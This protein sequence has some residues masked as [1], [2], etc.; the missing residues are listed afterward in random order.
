MSRASTG[1]ID[2]AAGT[3][4]ALAVT[5]DGH[6]HAWGVNGSGQLGDGTRIKHERPVRVET[7][8]SVVQVAAG[9]AH[10]LALT[11]DGR[12]LAWGANARGQLGIGSTKSARHPTTVAALSDVVSIATGPSH[13]VAITRSGELYTWGANEHAQLGDGSRRD[14][15]APVRIALTEVVDAAAG[16]NHTLALL[17][18]G[19]V[20]SW[21]A[22]ERGQLGTG[23]TAMALAPS[24]IDGLRAVAVRAGR[25]FSA[26]IQPDGT[27]MTWGA[28]DSG[29]LGDGS[30]FD[31]LTPAR[32]PALHDLSTLALGSRHAI[33]VTASGDVWTWGR[34]VAPVEAMSD[35]AHWGPSIAAHV[36]LRPPTITPPSASYAA[37]QTISIGSAGKN[38]T[39][40]YTLDGSDPTVDST[41]YLA[42][43]VVAVSTTVKARAYASSPHVEPGAVASAFYVIDMSPPTIV[44]NV[45]P[46]SAGA[47]FIT[48]VVVTFECADDSGAVACPAPVTVS[49]D[50]ASQLVSG[51][52]VDAAG[53]QATAAVTLNVDQSPPSIVLTDSPDNSTTTATQ[54]LLTGRVFDTASGLAAALRCNG[55]DVPVVQEAFE[56]VV[57]LR[58]GV[59]HVTLYYQRHC[60]TFR[61]CRDRHHQGRQQTTGLTIAPNARTM[62][63]REVAPL[64][65][66]DE[67]G[68]AVSGAAW[69][70]SNAG[71]AVLSN[72][73]PPVVTAMAAGTATISAIKDGRIAESTIIVSSGSDAATRNRS[74]DHRTNTRVHDGAADLHAPRRSFGAR[75]VPRR[76]TRRGAKPPCAR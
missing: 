7:V 35:I 34:G 33:A 62:V 61:T 24:A 28:N 8:A 11:R 43:F 16:S 30:L 73:D 76:N 54:V 48:P 10:S 41:P 72:D 38:V 46:P 45:S 36:E 39:I 1:V 68:A 64:S 65:L 17:R 32:G 22:G 51:T 9:R 47:W 29:Q 20:Y 42:P 14:R 63:V 75:H 58:P 23:S 66:T 50:G 12:V 25:N 26:A 4:H 59:N 40:R 18:D 21:G 31:R 69:E 55:G 60:G 6:V 70:S 3:R 5:G 27:L 2:V 57:S 37:P 15:L 56:C 13:S 74:L 44:A 67:S 71:I 49:G 52:A 19:S 53:N